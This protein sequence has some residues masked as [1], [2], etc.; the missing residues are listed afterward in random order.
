MREELLNVWPC[1]VATQSR[2][3]AQPCAQAPAQ[4]QR[5]ER[6]VCAPNVIRSHE[7]PNHPSRASPRRGCLAGVARR[8]G[9]GLA[10]AT[11]TLRLPNE[12]RVKNVARQRREPKAL[13]HAEGHGGTRAATTSEGGGYLRHGRHTLDRGRSLCGREDLDLRLQLSADE[14]AAEHFGAVKI[15]EREPGLQPPE[16]P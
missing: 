7:Q 2:E 14:D 13:C 16:R 11:A 15:V 4:R 8:D 9:E 6:R 10:T 3:S 5:P 12:Q 1:L